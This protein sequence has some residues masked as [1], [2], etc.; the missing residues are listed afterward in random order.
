MS[1]YPTRDSLHCPFLL[2]D[3]SAYG[4]PVMRRTTSLSS[5][6]REPSKERSPALSIATP[7]RRVCLIPA[8]YHPLPLQHG[9]V[10]AEACLRSWQT[11]RRARAVG[12]A[13][14]VLDET[15]PGQC[16]E[17]L[18]TGTSDILGV[19]G[20]GKRSGVGRARAVGCRGCGDSVVYASRRELRFI[21]GSCGC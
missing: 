15:V 3:R 16:C 9:I 20:G 12:D 4:L 17:G 21:V 6:D 13:T 7:S 5:A 10:P 19:V 14:L 2:A 8:R 1:Q 11:Y 18:L